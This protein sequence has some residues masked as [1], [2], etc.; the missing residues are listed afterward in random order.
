MKRVIKMLARRLWRITA[1][2]SRPVIRKF[3]HHLVG[4][5]GSA[6]A[7][8]DAPSPRTEMPANIDLAL[9]SVVRELA[10]LQIQVEILQHKIDDMQASDHDRARPE[11]RLSLVG[12]R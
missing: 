3:D 12:E 10:R 7:R 6:S 4:L 1:P 11:N 9:S 5:L 2:I 8:A